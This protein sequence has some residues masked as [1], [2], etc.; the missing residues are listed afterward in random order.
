MDQRG[1]LRRML[2]AVDLPDTTDEEIVAMKRDMIASLAGSASA[3]LVDPTF[4][5]PAA[6][7]VSGV[8]PVRPAAGRRARLSR[9][10]PR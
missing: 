3:F 2:A 1:T 10:A 4:G 5:L 8:P 9:N 7:Q 6:H